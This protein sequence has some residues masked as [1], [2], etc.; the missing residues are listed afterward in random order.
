M[1]FFHHFII[2]IMSLAVY[3]TVIST[4]K[5]IDEI[6]AIWMT[7]LHDDVIKGKHFP[8]YWPFVRWLPH[9]KASDAELWCFFDLRLNK[10][11]SKQWY[12]FNIRIMSLAVYS[13]VMSTLKCIDAIPAIWMTYLHDDV[14]KGKHFPRYWPFVRWLPHTKAS[15]A[16]LWCF[17]DLRLNKR[18]S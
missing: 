8:R 14:N 12:H 10:R 13:I 4:L 1:N 9:T 11:L 2:R 7:Y 17:F 6:P 3:S 16:E 5:C 15:D 18:L